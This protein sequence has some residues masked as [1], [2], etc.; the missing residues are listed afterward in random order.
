M[1]GMKFAVGFAII[2]LFAVAEGVQFDVRQHL[3]TSSRYGAGKEAT[4]D[5]Y[6]TTNAPPIGC[7][8]VHLN[9]VARHGTRAPTK[10]RAKELELFSERLEMLLKSAGH[11]VVGDAHESKQLPSWLIGWRSPWEGRKT[12]GQLTREGEEELYQL[13]KRIR[14]RFPELFNEDYHPDVYSITA[15][16]VPRA[17]ASAVAFGMGLFAGKGVLGPGRQQAFAVT[18]ESRANDIHLRFHDT[19][20]TYK[21]FKKMR[22]PAIEALLVDVFAEVSTSLL[23]HYNLNFTKEDVASLWFLCKQEA[24]LMDKTDQACGLFSQTEVELLEWADD[25]ALH[26]LKGYGESLNYRMGVPL[27]QNVVKSMEQVILAYADPHSQ[28]SVEKARLRFAHAETIIPFTCLLGLFLEASDIYKIETEQ[29]LQPPPKPPQQ[30]KWRGS[31]VAP[32]AANNML[33]LYKCPAKDV[34]F[35]KVTSTREHNDK[36]FVQILHNEKPASIPGCNGTNFCPFEVFKEKVA[37]AHLRHTFE[38]L[39]TSKATTENCSLTCKLM[40]FIRRMVLGEG[41]E[42]HSCEDRAEL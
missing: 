39:C 22:K 19:C 16:Q 24:A 7:T 1:G 5:A 38:S 32:F 12:N 8:P 11:T 3:G 21:D 29:P 26:H 27:L 20:Q 18:S 6:Q 35:G 2:L 10:K 13:G 37:G 31:T 41:A 28:G 15:T 23:E 40:R 30:R 36:F 34:S 42:V 17:S 9:L 4:T 33:V 14:E 25:I